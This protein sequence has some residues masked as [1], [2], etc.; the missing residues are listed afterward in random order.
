MA[1]SKKRNSADIYF[2][3]GIAV[4]VFYAL[5][6]IPNVVGSALGEGPLEKLK[7]LNHLGDFLSGIFAPVAF[8]FFVISVLIQRQ[9]F[10]LTREEM[11]SSRDELSKQVAQLRLSAMSPIIIKSIERT[12]SLLEGDINFI[13]NGINRYNVEDYRNKFNSNFF[14]S[15]ESSVSHLSDFSKISFPL[16]SRKSYEFWKLYGK[17]HPDIFLET[18]RGYFK[19]IEIANNNWNNINLYFNSVESLKNLYFQAGIL[20]QESFSDDMLSVYTEKKY[21]D[22]HKGVCL[23]LKDEEKINALHIFHDEI[24]NKMTEII[25]KAG[26]S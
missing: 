23:I 15:Y 26:G 24:S 7:E 9:E 19:F 3:L 8:I 25:R 16:N 1:V 11:S 14:D 20:P 4:L 22:L 17:D 2:A 21:L 10:Q 5:F 18:V 6:L 13:L 12:F